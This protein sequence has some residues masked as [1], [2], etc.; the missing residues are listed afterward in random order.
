M[1]R[2]Y[3]VQSASSWTRASTSFR[4]EIAKAHNGLL[5]ADRR[6]NELELSDGGEEVRRNSMHGHAAVMAWRPHM[7]PRAREGAEM[8]AICSARL[9]SCERLADAIR[10]L[11]TARVASAN[12]VQLGGGPV[13]R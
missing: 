7:P 1:N 3:C 6:R 4:A 5:P 12:Q 10:H 11:A 8:C 13:S 9:P 2:V